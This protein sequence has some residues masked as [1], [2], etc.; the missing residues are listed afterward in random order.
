[1]WIELDSSPHFVLAALCATA[2]AQLDVHVNKVVAAL[3]LST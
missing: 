1:M 3:I 2:H